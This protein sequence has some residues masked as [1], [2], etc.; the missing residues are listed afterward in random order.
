MSNK[1]AKVLEAPR[2]I[3]KGRIAIVLVYLIRF[4]EAAEKSTKDLAEKYGTTVGKID[5]IRKNRNFAY[6]TEDV[7]FTEAQKT[8]AEQFITKHED[9]QQAFDVIKL[10]NDLPTAT[11]EEAAAFAGVKKKSGG[12]PRTDENGEVIN[13]GG[14]NR[15]GKPKKEKA[16]K[17]EPEDEAPAENGEPTKDELLDL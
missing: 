12:Q 11:E 13:A 9:E 2:Q 7:R 3:I 6:V 16:D 8:E 10:I 4:V 17:K 1:E 15:Q 14:G 5:D